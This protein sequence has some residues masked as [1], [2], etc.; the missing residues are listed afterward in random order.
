MWNHYPAV[1]RASEVSDEELTVDIK[2]SVSP[3]WATAIGIMAK[4]NGIAK[5]ITG[6]RFLISLGKVKQ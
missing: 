3:E 2:V 5:K 6:T 1:T 4:E